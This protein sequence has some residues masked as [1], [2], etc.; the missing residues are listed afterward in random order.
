MM[1][2][3][4]A[5]NKAGLYKDYQEILDNLIDPRLIY[6]DQSL[7]MN[8][9]DECKIFSNLVKEKMLPGSMDRGSYKASKII[10]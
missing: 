3:R 1:W 2:S 7:T 8:Q 9:I 5:M 6:F 10:T 4:L